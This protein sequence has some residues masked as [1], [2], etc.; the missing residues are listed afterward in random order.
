MATTAWAG[1]AVAIP[2]CLAASTYLARLTLTVADRDD[3]TWYRGVAPSWRRQVVT[4]GIGSVLG[5]LAGR[6]A[7]ISALLPAF[8]LL[9]L[10]STVLKQIREA[11]PPAWE[12]ITPMPYVALQQMLD[13]PNAWGFRDYDKGAYVDD[14]SDDV[15]EIVAE[16]LPRKTSP[17]SVLLFYRLDGAYSAVADDETAFSGGRSAR[18]A[19]FIIAVCPTPE[20]LESDRVWVRSTWEALLPH[21]NATGVY[22]NALTIREQDRVRAAYGP[23]KYERLASTKGK[24]DPANVFHT[25]PTSSRHNRAAG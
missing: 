1:A 2:I 18:Y 9:A 13:E 5:A 24:Y 17:L 22:V 15:I 20:L 8:I 11:L 16:Q 25:T 4:A 23:A 21:A 6:A 3:A 10:T 7:G 12:F 19:V 14:I